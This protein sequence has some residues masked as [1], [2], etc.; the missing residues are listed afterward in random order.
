MPF[1]PETGTKLL[2]P[3]PPQSLNRSWEVY[4]G[5]E[6]FTTE[7]FTHGDRKLCAELES[8]NRQQGGGA[9]PY[10]DTAVTS[11]LAAPLAV[12]S[13]AFTGNISARRLKRSVK[14][15]VYEC[16][17][18]VVGRGARRSTLTETSEVLG[19][20]I[21]RVGQRTLWREVLCAWYLRQ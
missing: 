19:S 11:L 21:W 18:A 4:T 2:H 3:L 9:T 14:V 10:R 17:R 6:F 7:E 13:A 8:I 12:N 20:G 15:S 16:P 1:S 5:G